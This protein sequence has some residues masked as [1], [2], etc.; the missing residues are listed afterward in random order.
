MF[1]PDGFNDNEVVLYYDKT[2]NVMIDSRFGHE[3]LDIYRI[4]TPNQFYFFKIRKQNMYTY[5]VDGQPVELIYSD[6]DYD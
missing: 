6:L 3:V 5:G 2:R 4:I 1:E